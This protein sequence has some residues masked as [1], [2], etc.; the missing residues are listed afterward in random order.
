MLIFFPFDNPSLCL[1]GKL[2]VPSLHVRFWS[3]ASLSLPPRHSKRST[4][5]FPLLK[6][7]LE[8]CKIMLVYFRKRI[9]SGVFHVGGCTLM[10]IRL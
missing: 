9:F 8:F 1:G 4:R 7:G 2:S 6:K 10:F 3:E 5:D